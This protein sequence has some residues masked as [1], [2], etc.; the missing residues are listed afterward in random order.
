M[1]ASRSQPASRTRRSRGG[2]SGVGNLG[3]AGY[4]GPQWFR[5][6]RQRRYTRSAGSLCCRSFR[7]ALASCI[8]TFS[9]VGRRREPDRRMHHQHHASGRSGA[10]RRYDDRDRED[11]L[12]SAAGDLAQRPLIARAS[13]SQRAETDL[14]R[15]WRRRV[16]RQLLVEVND[17]RGPTTVSS[18]SFVD[19]V[20]RVSSEREN[21]RRDRRTG[22]SR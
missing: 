10:S 4:I 17:T 6:Q 2:W 15:T 20:A 22:V 9:R 3:V 21:N 19:C 12:K 1:S 7:R 11:A 8:E 13:S 5:G 14:D 16:D 18:L